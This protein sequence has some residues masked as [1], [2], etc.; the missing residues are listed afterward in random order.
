M[1]LLLREIIEPTRACEEM[2]QE[3]FQPFFGN[4]LEI[5]RTL[6]GSSRPDHELHRIGFSIIS[7]CVFYRAHHR[8]VE[9]MIDARERKD[10]F[11]AEE[12]AEH[13]FRFSHAAIGMAS[14]GVTNA[15][16]RST[17]ACQITG[18]PRRK[19]NRRKGL[20]TSCEAFPSC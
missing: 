19:S 17:D 9:M 5:L 1:R 8:I 18:F 12:L 3:G 20:N 6:C 7:Q 16:T 4:L 2:V 14:S 11:T 10:H 15:M 13:I